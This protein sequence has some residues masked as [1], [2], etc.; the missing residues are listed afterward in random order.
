MACTA[1]VAPHAVNQKSSPTIMVVPRSPVAT[2][3]VPAAK[4]LAAAPQPTIVVIHDGV[5][6]GPRDDTRGGATC[7][8]KPGSGPGFADSNTCSLDKHAWCYIQS[9]YSCT[10]GIKECN[11]GVCRWWSQRACATAAL[12]RAAA[13]KLDGAYAKKS[14]VTKLEKKLEKVLAKKSQA[15]LTAAITKV[16]A[17]LDGFKKP[18]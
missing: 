17:K 10:D 4:P 5:V 18:K 6:T 16:T 15:D 8:C 9:A 2:I 13:P 1:T 11:G 7:T 12:A 3:P 14:D